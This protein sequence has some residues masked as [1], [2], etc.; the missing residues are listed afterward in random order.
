M[1]LEIAKKISMESENKTLKCQTDYV[2]AIQQ[3]LIWYK[4]MFW[5]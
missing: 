4:N 2:K 5:Y 1:I 3:I